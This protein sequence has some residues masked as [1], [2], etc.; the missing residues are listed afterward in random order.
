MTKKGILIITVSVCL[1]AFAALSTLIVTNRQKEQPSNQKFQLNQASKLIE[2]ADSIRNS[3]TDTALFYYN[4][5]KSLLEPA[6]GNPEKSHLLGKTFTGLSY[7]YFLAGN[8]E[9]ALLNDSLAL[10]IATETNDKQIIAKVFLIRGTREYGNGE[11]EKAL[12]CY[13]KALDLAE[14]TNELELQAKIIASR[15][16]IFANQGNMP[17]TIEGFKQ[18]LE[19]G[20]QLNNKP[21]VAGNYINLSTVFMNM[22]KNDSALI[23]SNLAM[24]L[25]KTLNDKN[26]QVLC[27]RN[28]GNIYYGLSDFKKTIENFQ[29]SLQLSLEMND[30]LNIAK[31]Y[32]NLADI[33]L[34][35]GDIATATELLF[36]SIKIKE[37]LNDKLSLAKG[38]TGV[39]KLYYAQKQFTQALT[40]FRK[41][42]DINLKINSVTDI[43]GNYSSIASVYSGLNKLDSSKIYYNKALELYKQAEYTYGVAN[44]Y[45][46]LGDDYRTEHDFEKAETMFAEAL[47]LKTEIE[48]EEGVAVINAMLANLYL[49]MA[50]GKNEIS[51]TAIIRKA[52]LAGL[53]S[54]KTAKRIGALP[55][56]KDVS[57]VLKEIYKKQGKYR[58]SLEFSEIHN[59]LSDSLLNGEKVEALSFAEARWN[60]EKKQIEITNLENNQ[61]LNQEII[62]QKETEARQHKFIIIIISALFLFAIASTIV[63]ALYIRKRRDALYQKQLAK[64]AALRMQ[65]ARN[66]MSPHFFFNV[67]A[68]LNGLSKK[69]ELFAQKLNNLSLLLRKVIENIDQTAVSLDEELIAVK[70]FVDLFGEK[71]PEPFSVEYNI[72]EGTNL[73]RPIPAMILQIPVENA[74]KHGLMPIE[75]EKKLT[76]SITDNDNYQQIKITDNGI[77]LKASAGRS[78]GTGTG[79]KVLLQTIHLLNTSNKDKIKFSVSERAAVHPGISGTSVDIQ[80]PYTFNYAI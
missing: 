39:A 70:A 25:F 31:G 7:T 56:M 61:K 73:S 23:Y 9:L 14:E 34:H 11:Y 46:N 27:Y 17:K 44:V 24:E 19:I 42:L 15:A 49:A 80:I 21:L 75:G 43:G 64:M 60:V 55:V 41:A 36:K 63:I 12:D 38:Y 5:A 52:E 53:Q 4:K 65:N 40:Y 6:S 50:E 8:Y 20:K 66:T 59:T 67:L 69:P 10:N 33:Y 79:L 30:K 57:N 68:S 71:I 37:Q 51:S 3:N 45:I 54:Y 29:L 22:S 48:E 2:L 47:Q 35:V 58:E 28:I 78:T 76:I 77:G 32:H 1:I 72:P 62:A 18:A 26:G 74:I 16:M 13:E